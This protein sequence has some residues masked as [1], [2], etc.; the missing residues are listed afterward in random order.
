MRS[1]P[2]GDPSDPFVILLP[3]ILYF[4]LASVSAQCVVGWAPP[5]N[6]FGPTPHALVIDPLLY[7]TPFSISPHFLLICIL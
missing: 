1:V 6:I 3:L 7:L 4:Q 2:A 5:T